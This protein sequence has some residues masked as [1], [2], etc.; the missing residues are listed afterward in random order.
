[1]TIEEIR[2]LYKP[3]A[4]IEA[5]ALDTLRDLLQKEMEEQTEYYKAIRNGNEA[6]ILKASIRLEQAKDK[7]KTQ[8]A[9]IARGAPDSYPVE[10]VQASWNKHISKY[11]RD[12][13]EKYAKYAAA[14]KALSESFAELILMQKEAISDYNAVCRILFGEEAAAAFGFSLPPALPGIEKPHMMKRPETPN[15]VRYNNLPAYPDAAYF[16]ATGDMT[17]TAFTTATRTALYQAKT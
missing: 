9:F 16:V 14:R 17:K 13:D 15:T 7:T 3:R 4:E 10:E 5:E 2:S 12:F 11:N 1:M 8:K 6:E